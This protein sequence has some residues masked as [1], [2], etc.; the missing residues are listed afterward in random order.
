MTIMRILTAKFKQLRGMLKERW[1]ELSDDRAK[2][3]EGRKERLAGML[4][5]YGY[6]Q[7]QAELETER[8][9]ATGSE[10]KEKLGPATRYSCI[11][12]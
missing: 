1:G 9:F 10:R 7:E 11:R 12:G 8:F 5:S 2:I 6:T 3:V 4:L